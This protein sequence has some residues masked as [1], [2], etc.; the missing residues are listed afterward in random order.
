[1]YPDDVTD[2]ESYDSHFQL[3]KNIGQNNQ[4]EKDTSTQ[5]MLVI[6][7]LPLRNAPLDGVESI[8]QKLRAEIEAAPDK[9]YFTENLSGSILETYIDHLIKLNRHLVID[10][11]IYYRLGKPMNEN[12]LFWMHKMLE[13]RFFLRETLRHIVDSIVYIDTDGNNNCTFLK[14][15]ILELAIRQ[16]KVAD[17]VVNE[18]NEKRRSAIEDAVMKTDITVDFDIRSNLIGCGN[19]PGSWLSQIDDTSDILMRYPSGKDPGSDNVCVL[20]NIIWEPTIGFLEMSV[21]TN[22]FET[23]CILEMFTVIIRC[24][25]RFFQNR[26]SRNI[27]TFKKLSSLVDFDPFIRAIEMSFDEANIIIPQLRDRNRQ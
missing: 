26:I 3:Q 24:T 21:G 27:G 18:V 9:F 17:N 13:K 12:M 19:G 11:L 7:A 16:Y 14:Y 5:S 10:D 20:A 8:I 15:K 25:G 6:A 1:M 22:N 4:S 2:W 23:R